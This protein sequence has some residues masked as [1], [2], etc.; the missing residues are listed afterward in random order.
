MSMSH[1][2]YLLW[3]YVLFNSPLDYYGVFFVMYSMY[4]HEEAHY[5]V[6]CCTLWM[7]VGEN[8]GDYG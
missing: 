2:A 3:L 8:S 6:S 4:S 1:V 7:V 5:G